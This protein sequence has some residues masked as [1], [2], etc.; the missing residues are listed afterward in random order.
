MKNIRSTERIIVHDS[1]ADIFVQLLAKRF[2]EIKVGNHLQDPSVSLSG[3]FCPAAP[4]RIISMIDEA[5][6]QGAELVSGDLLISGPNS[7]IMQP[8]IVDKVKPSMPL[9]QQE[10]FGPIVCISRVSSEEEAIEM[11]NDTEYT[12]CASVFTKD[13]LR[14]MEVASQIQAGSCHVNGPTVYIEPPLPNGGIGGR[15]GYGRFGGTSG[16]DEFTN[17]KIVTL[18]KPGMS[19]VL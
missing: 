2:N 10:S 8:H 4:K 3:L 12:L 17:K 18:V 9:F 1:V 15:S 14:G 13:V 5:I 16:V 6:S 19:Y 7:T 11:A